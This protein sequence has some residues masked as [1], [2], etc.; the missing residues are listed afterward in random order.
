VLLAVFSVFI[1]E[2]FKIKQKSSIWYLFII[3][4]FQDARGCSR[5]R[6]RAN[7]PSSLASSLDFLIEN[8]SESSNRKYKR[9]QKTLQL[10][11]FEVYQNTNSRSNSPKLSAQNEPTLV[12]IKPEMSEIRPRFAL[13]IPLYPDSRHNCCEF[14]SNSTLRTYIRSSREPL[15]SIT[16]MAINKAQKAPQIP[17]N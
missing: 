16:A 10:P 9:Q 1:S 14:H 8:D 4:L 5:K 3:Q 6:P 7:A 15:S 11:Q 17:Q 2:S 13:E 12:S